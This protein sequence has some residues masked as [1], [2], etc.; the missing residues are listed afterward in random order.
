MQIIEAIVLGLIQGLTEF[1]PV[2]S[3]GHLV[4]LQNLFGMHEATQAFT[5][6]LHVATL[7]AVF[8]YY[9]KDIWAL[10]CHPFQRTTALLIAGTIPTVIIALLFND[11]F[12]SIFGSGKFIGFNFIFTGCILL[13]ADSR[14]GGRKKIRNMSIFDSLVVGLMQ[15]VAILPAVSRSGMTIS[16]CLGRNMDRE[17]AARFSFL[18]S[19]PAILGGMVLTIKDM[20]TGKVVLTEAI[21]LIPMIAGFIV[22]AI[23]GYFAIRFMVS[24]IKN[25]KLKWFS[26]YVFILGSILILDQFVLH[27]IVK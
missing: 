21:G 24:V 13:Y 15:G 18:L 1:L 6:L 22:A 7:I 5:I 20:I 25:G 14:K 9:W 26:V 3:S 2:S 17:N 27:M 4:L 19:I 11:T 23:S 8:V 12:D 16:A 10:I